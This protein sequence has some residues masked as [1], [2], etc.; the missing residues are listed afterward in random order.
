[1]EHY[2]TAINGVVGCVIHWLVVNRN[3]H[4]GFPQ[5]IK[6]KIKAS[7]RAC[8]VVGNGSFQCFFYFYHSLIYLIISKRN[9][10]ISNSIRFLK[11]LGNN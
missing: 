7:L 5:V 6:R 1:M 2:S 8:S 11:R 3:T 4:K 9:D 10:T